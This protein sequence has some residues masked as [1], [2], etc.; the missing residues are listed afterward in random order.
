MESSSYF[1]AILGHSFVSRAEQSI[2]NLLANHRLVGNFKIEG[3]GGMKFGGPKYETAIQNLA[4]A[5]AQTDLPVVVIVFLGDNDIFKK[6]SDSFADPE[7]KNLTQATLDWLQKLLDIRSALNA[8]KVYLIGPAVRRGRPNYNGTLEA[9]DFMMHKLTRCRKWVT[10]LTRENRGGRDLQ[11]LSRDN[12]HPRVETY[13][14]WIHSFIN[15][16]LDYMDAFMMSENST[17]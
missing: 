4:E 9:V 17:E 8:R 12:I 11:D 13:S 2:H 6:D 3:K 10:Y 14:T 1:A 16:S 15:L 5:T 7:T